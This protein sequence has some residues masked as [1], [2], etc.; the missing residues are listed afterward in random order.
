MPLAQTDIE[1]HPHVLPILR[2]RAR[3]LLAL[4]VSNP[5]SAGI[6]ATHQRWLLAHL[7]MERQFENARAGRPGMHASQVAALAQAADVASRNTAEAFLREMIAYGFIEAAADEQDQ[8]IRRLMV[9]PQALADVSA[10]AYGNL[11]TLDAFDAGGRAARFL[12]APQTLALL[13]PV[14]ARGFLASPDIRR[15]GHGFALF[16]VVDEGGAV[17]DRLISTC[18]DEA[19]GEGRRV[20]GM[21]SQSDFGDHLRLSRSHLTRKLAEAERDGVLG[22][23]GA[24]GRSPIWISAGFVADYVKRQAAELAA[25]EAGY[26]AAFA[27][28]EDAPAQ[29][30]LPAPL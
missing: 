22:W 30:D 19:D 8:R 23:T 25:I 2:E 24:R 20:T 10:W 7:A 18:A 1:R 21:A 9:T 4:H 12:A 13:Q 26:E 27:P 16:D 29:A 15:P 28:R 6:F 5:R 3:Q 14:A 11:A 17:M